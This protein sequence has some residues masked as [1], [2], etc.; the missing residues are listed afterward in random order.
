VETAQKRVEARNYQVRKHILE[1]DNVMNQQRDV[2]YGFRNDILDT[3]DPHAM[4][5]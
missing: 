5:S 2:V 1:Y 3:E 4:I